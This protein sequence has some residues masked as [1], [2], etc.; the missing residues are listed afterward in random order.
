MKEESQIVLCWIFPDNF[1]GYSGE[2]P[3]PKDCP[4]TLRQLG[5]ER[6][7]NRRVELVSIYFGTYGQG[8]CGFFGL[9]LE[10]TDK[11]PAEFIVL[12]LW[13]SENW[14]HFNDAILAKS[15]FQEFKKS[16]ENNRILEFDVQ[17]KQWK[18]VLSN[19]GI[20][21]V[22]PDPHTRPLDGFKNLRKL[23]V[24]DSLWDAWVFTERQLFV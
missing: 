11:Y 3:D 13:G 19:G 18:M 20:L 15:D 7:I 24:N 4:P 9:K 12:T 14:V 17:D 1:S 22:K 21:E 2:T 23:A 16:V 6:V 10:K 5:L 8:G